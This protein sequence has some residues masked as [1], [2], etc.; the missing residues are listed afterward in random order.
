MAQ[1]AQTLHPHIDA[2]HTGWNPVGTPNP[3]WRRQTGVGFAPP[4]GHC[5]H[6]RCAVSNKGMSL[7]LFSQVAAIFLIAS[8]QSAATTAAVPRVVEIEACRIDLTPSGRAA[9][10]AATAIYEADIDN[11]GSVWGVRGLRVPD[12]FSSFVRTSEFESCMRRWKFS[13]AGK[14]PI[15]FYAGTTGRALNEW[16]ITAGEQGQSVRLTLPR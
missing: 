4:G 12:T 10:F 14:V 5:V 7:T 1:T 13:G 9:S 6:S 8:T 16:S 15:A 2:S 3:C 11:N